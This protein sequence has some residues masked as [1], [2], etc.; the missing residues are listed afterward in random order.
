MFIYYFFNIYLIKEQLVL[1][2][3]FKMDLLKYTT[4]KTKEFGKEKLETKR[5]GT[6]LICLSGW[7]KIRMFGKLRVLILNLFLFISNNDEG[8][9][10]EGIKVENKEIKMKCLKLN[11]TWKGKYSFVEKKRV[12]KGILV[13]NGKE[14][15]VGYDSFGNEII[16]KRSFEGIRL[17]IIGNK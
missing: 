13:E 12:G 5:N 6:E 16:R 3:L 1:M 4:N 14:F 15:L 10:F 7:I 2:D 9:Y 11:E 17:M 8:R